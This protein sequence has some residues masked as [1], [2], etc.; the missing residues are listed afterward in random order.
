MPTKQ[1]KHRWYETPRCEWVCHDLQAIVAPSDDGWYAY[2]KGLRFGPFLSAIDAQCAVE[3]E[4]G[5]APP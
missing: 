3:D 4:A 5:K 1:L 2:P